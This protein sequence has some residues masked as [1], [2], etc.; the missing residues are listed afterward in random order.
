MQPATV[1]GR[2]CFFSCRIPTKA[3]FSVERGAKPKGSEFGLLPYED[4]RAAEG[5]W[6]FGFL[7][8][9]LR[10]EVMSSA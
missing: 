9:I 3:T 2:F 1:S 7:F 4:S 8:A 5:F 10:K 6:W